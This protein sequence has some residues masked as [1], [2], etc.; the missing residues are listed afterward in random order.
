MFIQGLLDYTDVIKTKDLSKEEFPDIKETWEQ[1]AYGLI[2]LIYQIKE[3]L[4]ERESFKKLTNQ[5][6]QCDNEEAKKDT[7]IRL[8]ETL[9]YSMTSIFAIE[10]NI[11]YDDFLESIKNKRKTSFYEDNIN[12]FQSNSQFNSFSKK[13]FVYIAKQ[14]NEKNLYKIGSTKNLSERLN[15]FK[16]GNC[17]V[18]LIASKQCEDRISVENWF[19]KYFADKRFEREW[20]LL[21]E[22]D[23]NELVNIFDFNFHLKTNI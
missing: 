15:T 2:G 21:D 11:S 8:L 5:I 1:I 4:P 16:T 14:L 20:F 13:G 23:L 22:Q 3:K 12:N 6:V 19:H 18:E 7:I 10:K 17:Y 9:R